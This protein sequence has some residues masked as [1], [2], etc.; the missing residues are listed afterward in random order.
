MPRLRALSV[1]GRGLARQTV[2][3]TTTRPNPRTRSTTRVNPILGMPVAGSFR[4]ASTLINV[5]R[6]DPRV[7]GR[8]G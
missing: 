2:M 8:A 6:R 4:V 7:P 3:I 1:P 5:A